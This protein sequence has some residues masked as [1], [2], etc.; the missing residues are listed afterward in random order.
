MHSLGC[1]CRTFADCVAAVASLC[2][3]DSL[4]IPAAATNTL[5]KTLSRINIK[6]TRTSAPAC[7]VIHIPA[8]DYV[9]QKVR[10]QV[11]WSCTPTPVLQANRCCTA[12]LPE[13]VS[14]CGCADVYRLTVK[15][16]TGR[17]W[18]SA[19]D[20]MFLA[21]RVLTLLSCLP[22]PPAA[23][24]AANTNIRCMHVS[25]MCRRARGSVLRNTFYLHLEC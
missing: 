23:P 3:E 13:P 2:T 24:A 10:G 20:R 21:S 12:L 15:T 9:V 1:S 7:D 18:G 14:S 5:S 11:Q 25:F 22:A 16:C 4:Y 6:V 17:K 8:P 19:G